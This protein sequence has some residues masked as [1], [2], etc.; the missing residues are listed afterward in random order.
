MSDRG[1]KEILRGVEFGT[2]RQDDGNRGIHDFSDEESRAEISALIRQQ[3]EEVKAKK[4]QLK[5]AKMA[6]AK[7]VAE[8]EG[9]STQEEELLGQLSPQCRCCRCSTDIVDS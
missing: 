7:G 4:A 3:E 5:E 8:A 2:I 6:Q 9:E 1:V